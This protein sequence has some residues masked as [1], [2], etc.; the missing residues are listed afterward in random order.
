MPQAR[1]LSAF[2]LPYGVSA[3]QKKRTYTYAA[4]VPQAQLPGTISSKR[5]REN[6]KAPQDAQRDAQPQGLKK[7]KAPE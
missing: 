5:E 2:I 7:R 1:P 6:K 4:A 3:T